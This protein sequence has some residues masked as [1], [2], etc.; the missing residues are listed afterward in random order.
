MYAR[1]KKYLKSYRNV[2]N[3]NKLYENF[4]YYKYESRNQNLTQ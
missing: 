3:N 1:K 2:P 4:K